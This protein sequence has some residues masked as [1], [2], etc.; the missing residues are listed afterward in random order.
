MLIHEMFSKAL[1][2]Y[3]LVITISWATFFLLTHYLINY[4]VYSIDNKSQVI[5]KLINNLFIEFNSV[6]EMNH[7]IK[8]M[9]IVLII[10]IIFLIAFLFCF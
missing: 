9:L 7:K 3:T 10:L 2:N 8:V 1:D 4:M 5:Y 6:L